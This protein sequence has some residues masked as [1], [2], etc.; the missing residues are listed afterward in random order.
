[1]TMVAE[2]LWRLRGGAN[3]ACNTM[4]EHW[5]VPL[6]PLADEAIALVKELMDRF[7]RKIGHSKLLVPGPAQFFLRTGS[8]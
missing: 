7:R 1:M 2:R 8:N 4:H 6:Q 5:F 3:L